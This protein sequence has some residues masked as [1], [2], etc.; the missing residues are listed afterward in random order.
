VSESTTR[1][2]SYPLRLAAS[3]KQRAEFL[4]TEDRVPLNHFIN[5]AVAEKISRVEAAI[6][7][8]DFPSYAP[9]RT[10]ERVTHARRT[11]SQVQQRDD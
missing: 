5:L 11:M 6:G 7:K 3:L 10:L 8:K 4:A 9:D 1:R 2:I